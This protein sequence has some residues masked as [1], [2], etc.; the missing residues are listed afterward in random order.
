MVDYVMNPAIANIPVCHA[1]SNTTMKPDISTKLNAE[2]YLICT[3][4][5]C[6][7]AA[8]STSASRHIEIVS[9]AIN[10]SRPVPGRFLSF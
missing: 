1:K 9:G 6:T 7:I 3:L 2:Q 4:R 5:L 8:D 10:N